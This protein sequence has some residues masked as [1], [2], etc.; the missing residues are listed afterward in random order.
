VTDRER[1]FWLIVYR[2]LVAI[3]KGLARYLEIE[4]RA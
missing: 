3:C 2:S 4:K 1:E